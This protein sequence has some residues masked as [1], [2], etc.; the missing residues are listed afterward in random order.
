M[1]LGDLVL[2]ILAIVVFIIS[3]RFIN[4]HGGDDITDGFYIVKLSMSIVGILVCSALLFI[5][6]I[7]Y[8]NTI[9]LW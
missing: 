9:N 8:L 7:M 4:K 2:I 1:N 6:I 5:T 3:L